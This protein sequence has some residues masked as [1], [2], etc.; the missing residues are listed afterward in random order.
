MRRLGIAILGLFSGLLVGFVAHEIIAGI[1]LGTTGQVPSL[2]VALLLGYL[3]PVLAI[4]GLAV[5][6]VIDGRRNRRNDLV[7]TSHC[8]SAG[9][10]PTWRTRS[11]FTSGASRSSRLAT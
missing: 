10:R 1:V 2:P 9:L 5:A 11:T 6:L 8:R 4:G 7:G 3:T